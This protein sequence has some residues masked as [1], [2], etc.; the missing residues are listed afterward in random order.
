MLSRDLHVIN[1][2]K[3]SDL[4]SEIVS[5]PCG[6]ALLTFLMEAFTIRVLE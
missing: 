5:L 4:S 6:P 2:F 3:L 1:S